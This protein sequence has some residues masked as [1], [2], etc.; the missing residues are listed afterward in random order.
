MQGDFICRSGLLARP[1]VGQVGDCTA[2]MPEL[3]NE[4]GDNVPSKYPRVLLYVSLLTSGEWNLS[5]NWLLRLA[6]SIA[7]E[8]PTPLT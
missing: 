6:W 8:R 3:V 7:L 2:C 4:L 1:F 5:I